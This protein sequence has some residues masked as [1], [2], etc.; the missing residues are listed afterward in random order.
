[1]IGILLELLPTTLFMSACLYYTLLGIMHIKYKWWVVFV[2]LLI[3]MLIYA[4]AIAPVNL[5]DNELFQGLFSILFITGI[6]GAV[7]VYINRG[8]R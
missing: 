5:F 7:R 2:A 6:I 1:M 8:K 3:A 4:L